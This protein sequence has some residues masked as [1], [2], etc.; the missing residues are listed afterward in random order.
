M[1]IGMPPAREAHR[2]NDDAAR[3]GGITVKNSAYENGPPGS[4]APPTNACFYVFHAR[5]YNIRAHLRQRARNEAIC[6]SA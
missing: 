1:H 6:F 4:G 2:E 5:Q 3:T